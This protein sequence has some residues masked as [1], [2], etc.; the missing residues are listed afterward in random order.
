MYQIIIFSL[1]FLTSLI[2]LCE[3]WYYYDNLFAHTCNVA[4]NYVYLV[5][6]SYNFYFVPLQESGRSAIQ[7]RRRGDK[8]W[9]W[10]TSMT[11]AYP[12]LIIIIMKNNI[13]ILFYSIHFLLSSSDW[14]ERSW[15]TGDWA[16]GEGC[17]TF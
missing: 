9:R 7:V 4:V 13:I 11:H 16:Q 8:S 1:L 3:F 5:Q 15:N 14:T 2:L 12:P 10:T 6:H 17:F